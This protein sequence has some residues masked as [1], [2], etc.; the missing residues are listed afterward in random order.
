MHIH[1]SGSVAGRHSGARDSTTQGHGRVY[2][3][4]LENTIEIANVGC[5]VHA[6]MY[7][8]HV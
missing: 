3:M 1:H 2:S 7:A 4:W 5:R 8:Q 6:L